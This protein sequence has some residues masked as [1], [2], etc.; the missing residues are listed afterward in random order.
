MSSVLSSR[1]KKI[2]TA[3]INANYGITIKEIA[4]RLDVSKRTVL[5]EMS[6]VY[7]WFKQYNIEVD[8][9]TNQGIVINA[10]PQEIE[11]LKGSL[12][13]ELVI[14]YYS[15]KE[16]L[17]YLITELLESK[18]PLKLA[19]F[20]SVLGV[21]EATISH[22][23]NDLGN[24]IKQYDLDLHRKQGYGIEIKG[25]E[26]NKRKA[27]LDNLYDALD[28]EEIK[29]AVSKTIGMVNTTTRDVR[30]KL[31]DLIDIDT[32][33][34]I[35]KSISESEK[36]I[37]FKF[38]ESSYTALAVHL[39]LAVQRL[40]NDERIMMNP[41]IL[42]DIKLFDEYII[43]NKLIKNLE[44]ILQLD[45]PEDEIGY[46]TMHLKGARYK[47]GIYD[48][49]ILRFNEMVISNYQLASMINEMISVAEQ[50]TGY[51]LKQIDSLL[52]GL[53]DHL[54]PAISRLE[55]KLNIRNPLLEQIKSQYPDIYAVSEKC[56]KV[57]TKKLGVELPDSEIGYIAMHIGS[58][59]EQ[60][61][62]S[63]Q[64]KDVEVKVIV[65]CIS[66]IGTSKMLA[67]R[68][69][70]EFKNIKISRVFSTTDVKNEWLVKHRIDLI[71]STVH[72]ENTIV[73]ILKVNPL[74]LKNDIK[75]VNNFINTMSRT[76]KG[77][78]LE[79][80]ST[81]ERV[82]VLKEY[83]TGVVDILNNFIIKESLTVNTYTDMLH[84][85]AESITDNEGL[86]KEIVRR[87]EI[88]SIVFEDQ[89]LMFLHTRSEYVN[90]LGIGIYRN[91]KILEHENYH[92]NTVIMLVAPKVISPEQLEVVGEISAALVN[93]EKFIHN[94]KYEHK[95]DL[96]RRIEQLLVS[97][98]EAKI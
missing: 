6:S 62:N 10:S 29:S 52:I 74:L 49:K 42:E 92:F 44:E 40:K 84:Y 27:L 86:Y 35:E 31:L 55:L 61:K 26:R 37:G 70:K 66:G 54:R 76:R 8:R 77:M 1:E 98:F 53:V 21:S 25:K 96:Y 69:K 75:K 41:S 34:V 32:I 90:H 46:V 13:E 7:D 59:I 9:S 73:P 94:I 79:N 89:N 12:N 57:V 33:Q 71:I 50:E 36:D 16:R 4:D 24:Q 11:I 78:E 3:I 88:G 82:K 97:F 65:T 45:I 43:A 5:R 60:L 17:L 14:Q 85:V 63:N 38:A 67:E 87:E 64:A 56:S 30:S 72:F 91:E 39:A 18:E 23:L 83:S 93:D 68:L 95:E 80:I 81:L 51:Q 28:G 19:Y 2:I 48:T 58:A 22:D 47:S 20:A 15:K